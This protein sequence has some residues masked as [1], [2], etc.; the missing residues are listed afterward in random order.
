MFQ[1]LYLIFKMVVDKAQGAKVHTFLINH[2]GS[3]LADEAAAQQEI[4][5]LKEACKGVE[6]RG[7]TVKLAEAMQAWEGL[8][9]NADPKDLGQALMEI[10]KG[11]QK[12]MPTVELKNAQVVNLVIQND[13]TV[14]NVDALNSLVAAVTQALKDTKARAGAGY[15]GKGYNC[16]KGDELARNMGGKESFGL[17]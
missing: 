17:N 9:E 7:E 2:T 4:T 8:V 1:I 5:L 14:E 16:Y 3:D 6:E 10:Q 15:K 11:I 13:W 12:K